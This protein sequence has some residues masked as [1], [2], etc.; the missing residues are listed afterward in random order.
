[1]KPRAK[2]A[3]EETAATSTVADAGDATIAEPHMAPVSLNPFAAAMEEE[4]EAVAEQ[5]DAVVE[6]DQAVA[7]DQTMENQEEEVNEGFGDGGEENPDFTNE[8]PP[9]PLKRESSIMKPAGRPPPPP[10]K[11]AVC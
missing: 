2:A 3:V 4:N 5:K 8:A 11:H 9:E 1:M 10:P 7:A 6:Q